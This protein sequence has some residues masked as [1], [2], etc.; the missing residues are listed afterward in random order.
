MKIETL[1]IGDLNPALY[2]P[3]TITDEALKGLENSIKTFGYIEPIVVNTRD[4]KNIII[5]GHQRFKAM[6]NMGINQAQCVIVDLDTTQ[7]K[8][9]NIAA[10]NQHISGSWDFGKLENVLSELKFDFDQFDDV[11]FDRLVEDLSSGNDED[12]DDEPSNDEEKKKECPQCGY[13]YD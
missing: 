2:N 6:T 10:N 8:A 9:L 4:G 13:E 1:N 7:E 3:R 11:N 5:S 12:F